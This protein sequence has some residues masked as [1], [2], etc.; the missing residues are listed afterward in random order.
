MTSKNILVRSSQTLPMLSNQMIPS[1][2]VLD[3]LL[4]DEAPYGDY[5]VSS[6]NKVVMEAIKELIKQ[7]ARPPL[8]AH[9]PTFLGKELPIEERLF[10]ARAAVKI[11]TSQV[12]MHIK[13]EL[14]EKLFR[15]IDMMHDPDEWEPDDIPIIESSFKAFLSGLLQINPERGPG[16]GLTYN[17]NLIASWRT[18]RDRLIIEFMPNKVKWVITR[19]IDGELEQFVGHVLVNRLLNS[20]ASYNPEQWFSKKEKADVH[21]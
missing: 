18:G 10:D 6:E 16:L 2:G 19:F 14:R 8:T 20:L 4:P 9:K 1:D 15:Q 3:K 5:L 11:L 13:P 17:G 7:A 21:T 12:S